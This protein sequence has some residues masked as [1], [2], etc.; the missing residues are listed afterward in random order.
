MKKAAP[1]LTVEGLRVAFKARRGALTALRD[2]SFSLPQGR[3]LALVGESGS[4]KSVSSL[5]IM[6]LLPRGG[7]IAAGAH[8]LSHSGGG[9]NRPGAG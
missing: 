8:R 9:R 6:G 2:V 4:G 7:E 1:A 5:A 3:T